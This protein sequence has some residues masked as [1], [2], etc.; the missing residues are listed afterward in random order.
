MLTKLNFKKCR[1]EYQQL[2]EKVANSKVRLNQTILES[3]IMEGEFDE[4]A[5]RFRRVHAERNQSIDNWRR[6]LQVLEDRDEE[7]MSI[8]SVH[9]CLHRPFTAFDNCWVR[10]H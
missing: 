9:I 1:G 7:I 8:S 2:G 10:F 6:T 3:E 4:L 5:K